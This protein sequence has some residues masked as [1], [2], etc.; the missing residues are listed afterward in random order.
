[1]VAVRPIDSN[2]S[3]PQRYCFLLLAL[4]EQLSLLLCSLAQLLFR[5]YYQQTQCT[6]QQIL[7]QVTT[8]ISILCTNVPSD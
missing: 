3:L 8:N 1:M 2:I 6:D 4:Q 7:H 5:C